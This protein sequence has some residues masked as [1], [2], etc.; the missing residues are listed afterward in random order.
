MHKIV[1]TAVGTKR[2]CNYDQHYLVS[3]SDDVTFGLYVHRIIWQ[4]NLYGKVGTFIIYISYV[5]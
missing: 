5:L 3:L 2:L 4:N 1:I